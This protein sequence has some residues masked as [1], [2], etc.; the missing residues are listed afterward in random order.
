MKC[1]QYLIILAFLIIVISSFKFLN[2]Q[3]EG[4]YVNISESGLAE[5]THIVTVKDVVTQ[6]RLLAKPADELIIVTDEIGIPVN[7]TLNDTLV[8]AETYGVEVLNITYLTYGIV[9]MVEGLW[10]VRFSCSNQCEII[11]PRDSN[12]VYMNI[13]PDEVEAVDGRV[14]MLMPPGSYEVQYIILP[15]VSAPPPITQSPPP[16]AVLQQSNLQF[17]LL[18]AIALVVVFV[19]YSRVKAKSSVKLSGVDSLI[20]D[21]LKSRGGA[22]QDDIAKDLKLP[23]STL[24]RALSN[25]VKNG[26]VEV[27]RVARRNYVKLKK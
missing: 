15:K 4:V 5:V 26:L 3:S 20:L 12:I 23:K 13:I 2:A 1:K 9:E 6:V 10:Y 14:R 19:V 8:V 25:L 11:L 18:V 27:R 17:L 7:Y 21:Y 16:L 22:Y 24:S